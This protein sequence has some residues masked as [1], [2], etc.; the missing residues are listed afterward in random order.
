MNTIGALSPASTL[1]KMRTYR[2]SIEN[3]TKNSIQCAF[4]F[5]LFKAIVLDSLKNFLP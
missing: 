4:T 3:Y 2:H 1:K 5:Y